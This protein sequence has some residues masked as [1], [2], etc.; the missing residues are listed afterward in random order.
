MSVA[1]I[2]RLYTGLNAVIEEKCDEGHLSCLTREEEVLIQ[3]SCLQTWRGAECVVGPTQNLCYENRSHK[4]ETENVPGGRRFWLWRCCDDLC[5]TAT[6]FTWCGLSI[7]HFSQNQQKVRGKCKPLVNHVC[8]LIHEQLRIENWS[9]FLGCALACVD[10]GSRQCDENSSNGEVAWY[11][12]RSSVA[13]AGIWSQKFTQNCVAGTSES[14][15]ARA[16]TGGRLWH[17]VD[18]AQVRWQE[19]DTK[20]LNAFAQDLETVVECL[21]A[22]EDEDIQAPMEESW[23]HD[24]A[25]PEGEVHLRHPGVKAMVR[26][27]KRTK[28]AL[29]YLNWKRAAQTPATSNSEQ[30]DRWNVWTSYVM[31]LCFR[32]S[33]RCGRGR[34]L[35]MWDV[36]TEKAGSDGHATPSN[37]FLILSVKFCM[38]SFSSLMKFHLC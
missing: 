34:R 20:V 15:G 38:T 33:F 2:S 9:S 12:V 17:E 35:W 24:E 5:W 13:E 29:W 16:R 25:E 8:S 1:R 36:R 30:R 11:Y 21:P 31:E 14:L 10:S 6:V 18:L 19:S 4:S 3:K 27:L 32:C 26:V 23:E 28:N 37:L 22:E 7:R